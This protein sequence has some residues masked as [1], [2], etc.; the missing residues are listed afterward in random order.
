VFLGV[1]VQHIS[2]AQNRVFDA[3]REVDASEHQAFAPLS[4]ALV[5]QA[6]LLLLAFVLE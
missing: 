4:V 1:G 5:R 6:L 2:D 3:D